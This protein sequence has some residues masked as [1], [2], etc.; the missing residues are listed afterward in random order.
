MGQ[1]VGFFSIQLEFVRWISGL[2]IHVSCFVKIIGGTTSKAINNLLFYSNFFFLKIKT[3]FLSIL[4]YLR[5]LKVN[6]FINLILL[7]K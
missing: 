6:C 3:F 5:L 7:F 4:P 2:Y 1:V